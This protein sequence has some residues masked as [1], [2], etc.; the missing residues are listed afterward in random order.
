MRGTAVFASTPQ[1]P[2]PAAP[3][4]PR[5]E[6]VGVAESRGE[7]GTVRTAMIATDTND[8]IMA[9][10]GASV[11]GRYTVGTVDAESVDL[12]DLATGATRRL[13]LQ[14]Q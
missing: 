5:L 11:A 14:R 13:V 6:L 2:L 3:V 9:V 7:S 8:L 12:V 4:E 10:R 1:P